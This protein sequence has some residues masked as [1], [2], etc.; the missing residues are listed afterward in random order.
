MDTISDLLIRVKNAGNA[1]HATVLVPYSKFKEAVISVLQKEGFVKGFSKKGKKVTRFI[2]VELAYVGE[3]PKIKG[4]ERVSKPSK[5]VY[6]KVGEVRSVRQ[7]YG[8]L[9]L[10]T[11]KG[12]L[13]DKQAKREQ[14]GGE[15]LFKIW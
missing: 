7:G 6:T 10:S 15:S 5:R 12:I 3:N 14:V 13:T 11:P 2:E 9:I 4:V 1:G 8:M